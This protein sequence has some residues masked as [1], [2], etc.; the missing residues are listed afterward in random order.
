MNKKDVSRMN[1]S[2]VKKDY[3]HRPEFDNTEYTRRTAK[4]IHKA[5]K[6][7]RKLNPMMSAYLDFSKKF[8]A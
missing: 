4:F 7:T 8:W 2:A 5:P 1:T 3:R 6:G